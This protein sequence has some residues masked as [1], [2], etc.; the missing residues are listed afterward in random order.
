MLGKYI[1]PGIFAFGLL[2]VFFLGKADPKDAGMKAADYNEIS[3]GLTWFLLFL[4][5][6]PFALP[7]SGQLSVRYR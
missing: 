6:L 3:T 2:G 5:M 1:F 7:K 4:I